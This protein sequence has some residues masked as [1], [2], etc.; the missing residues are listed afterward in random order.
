VR[1]AGIVAAAKASWECLP[2]NFTEASFDTPYTEAAID[3]AGYAFR[4]KMPKVLQRLGACEGSQ[5]PRTCSYWSSM[6]TLA[7][8]ADLLKLGSQFL[9]AIVPVLAGGATL[10]GGCTLHLRAL[11]GPVLSKDINEGLGDIF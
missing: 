8:R 1:R 3:S 9:E 5:W 7:H 2:G 11:H 6:H 4:A 10:C